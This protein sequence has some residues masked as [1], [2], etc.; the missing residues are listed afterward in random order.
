MRIGAA[1]RAFFGLPRVFDDPSNR[2][3]ALYAVAGPFRFA[4]GI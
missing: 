3:L 2:E 1:V 4:R